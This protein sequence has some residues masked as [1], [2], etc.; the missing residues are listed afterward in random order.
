MPNDPNLPIPNNEPPAWWY[1]TLVLITVAALIVT[2][3]I[4]TM[5]V[6]I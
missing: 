4:L 1:V 6:H 5:G 2:P 3:A